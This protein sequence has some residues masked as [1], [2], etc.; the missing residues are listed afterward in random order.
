LQARGSGGL[1]TYIHGIYMVHGSSTPRL[2]VK[3]LFLTPKSRNDRS[4]DSGPTSHTLGTA[5][6]IVRGVEVSIVRSHYSLSASRTFSVRMSEPAL[7][8]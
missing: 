1:P 8:P 7:L 4:L 6:K 2:E 3:G 5:G